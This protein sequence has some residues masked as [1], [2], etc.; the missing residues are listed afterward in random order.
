MSCPAGTV[1]EKEKTVITTVAESEAVQGAQ[2]L[3]NEL[4]ET[5]ARLLARKHALGIRLAYQVNQRIP[6]PPEVAD[7]TVRDASRKLA[8]VDRELDA[9]TRRIDAQHAALARADVAAQ[10]TIVD[11]ATP[12][13]R[14]LVEAR[15]HAKAALAER[16]RG[17]QTFLADLR[18]RGVFQA[19]IIAE[20]G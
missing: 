15:D 9:L 6:V 16:E 2:A 14:Q 1:A 7:L 8:D 5:Q 13:Y 12:E 18:R 4:H 3:L 11:A 17:I 19:P 10:A 20:R